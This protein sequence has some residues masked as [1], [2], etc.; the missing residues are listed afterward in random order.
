MGTGMPF[1]VRDNLANSSFA[2]INADDF[3]GTATFRELIY[4]QFDQKEF[5]SIKY[6]ALLVIF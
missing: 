3:Y 6:G 1:G 4:F 2:V 5:N